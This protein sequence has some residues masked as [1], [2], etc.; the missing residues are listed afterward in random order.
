MESKQTWV[1]GVEGSVFIVTGPKM[2]PFPGIDG[3][4]YVILVSRDS[5]GVRTYLL[6][7]D[8]TKYLGDMKAVVKEAMR[9]WGMMD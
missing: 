8:D 4:R 2:E 1:G 9:R 3:K 5:I 6:Y 7:E